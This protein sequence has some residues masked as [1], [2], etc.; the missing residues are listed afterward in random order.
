MRKVKRAEVGHEEARGFFLLKQFRKHKVVAAFSGR[1]FQMNFSPE[2]SK[3]VAIAARRLFCRLAGVSFDQL[4]CMEQVHGANIVRVGTQDAGRGTRDPATQ[5]GGTDA[6]VTDVPHLVLSARTADCAPVF[7]LDPK[8]HVI[9]IAHIGWRGASAKLASKLVQV[10]RMQFISKPE[11]LV[12]ALG[13]T[14]RPCCYQVGS[15]FQS[16]FGSFVAKRPT[17]LYFDLPGYII[18][19]L[20]TGGV[21]IA[22]IYDS[23]LCTSC[24]NDRFPSYRKEGT[25]VRHM[26]SIISLI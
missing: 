25:K 8:R 11:D 10:F 4:V 24:L 1:R 19:E 6:L 20:V 15:E 7:F 17:G 26:L 14:I 5:I 13:P 9:G 3:S 16:A 21:P 18:Q 12:V 22:S 2:G 23:T